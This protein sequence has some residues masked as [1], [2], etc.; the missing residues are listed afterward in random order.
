M[1]NTSLY[2]KAEKS[3]P[4]R[5]KKFYAKKHSQLCGTWMYW[6]LWLQGFRFSG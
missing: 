3:W 1:N 5:I 6:N 2:W 4:S